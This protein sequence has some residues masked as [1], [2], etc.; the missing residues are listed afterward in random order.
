ME[1]AGTLLRTSGM[2]VQDVTL[3][4]GYANQRHFV[5]SFKKY[6][7]QTP[8]DFKQAPEQKKHKKTEQ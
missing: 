6:Y 7:G 3:T 8:T 2:L 4:C 1:R 5:S